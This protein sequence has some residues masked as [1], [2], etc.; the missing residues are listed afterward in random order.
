[1]RRDWV[2]QVA[3]LADVGG[4]VD[5]ETLQDFDNQPTDAG[6]MEEPTNLGVVVGARLVTS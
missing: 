6:R 5:V 3:K 1:M 4:S 2:G